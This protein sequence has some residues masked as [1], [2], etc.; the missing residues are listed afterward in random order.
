MKSVPDIGKFKHRVIFSVIEKN[1]DVGGGREEK[2]IPIKTVWA[3][4]GHK[5]EQM[6]TAHAQKRAR[7]NYQVVT[8]YQPAL[9]KT[10]QVEY[11]GQVLRIF[12]VFNLNEEN[13]FLCFEC[14]AEEKTNV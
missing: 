7:G 14:E 2:S 4:V 5:K 3:F 12:S 8:R 9:L 13:R 10:G 11:R 1:C 6:L